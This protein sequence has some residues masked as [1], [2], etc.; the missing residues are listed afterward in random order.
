MQTLNVLWNKMKDHFASAE[1]PRE[2]DHLNHRDPRD[3]FAV[4][5]QVIGPVRYMR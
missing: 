5:H 4:Q 3:D 1:L 2:F